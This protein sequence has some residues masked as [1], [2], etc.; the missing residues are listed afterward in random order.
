MRIIIY[1]CLITFSS[2]RLIP[3]KNI[4]EEKEDDRTILLNVYN[5][6]YASLVNCINTYLSWEQFPYYQDKKLDWYDIENECDGIKMSGGKDILGIRY[7][8]KSKY[9][10]QDTL[11]YLSPQFSLTNVEPLHYISQFKFN[12]NRIKESLLY[13]SFHISSDIADKHFNNVFVLTT[14][15]Q[16]KDTKQW[17]SLEIYV[18]MP[19]DLKIKGSK[20]RLP[21]NI[22]IYT[23]FKQSNYSLFYERTQSDLLKEAR[24]IKN[25]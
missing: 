20:D 5:N 2:C 8:T 4:K 1:L 15:S 7:W 21:D 11:I 12:N 10:N 6:K 25:L 16:K 23:S 17:V 22:D 18:K 3:A 19:D 14:L 9:S 13:Q 24:R